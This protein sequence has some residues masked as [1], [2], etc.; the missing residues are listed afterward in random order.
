MIDAVGLIHCLRTPRSCRSFAA[1]PRIVS[2][3]MK[4]QVTTVEQI[5]AEQP[6]RRVPDALLGRLLRGAAGHP[7]CPIGRH[8]APRSARAFNSVVTISLGVRVRCSDRSST[9]YFAPCIRLLD[10]ALGLRS[11]ACRSSPRCRIVAMRAASVRTAR[12][13]PKSFGLDDHGAHVCRH[14]RA[15]HQAAHF[16]LSNGG[17][18]G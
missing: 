1:E 2:V 12:R 18:S 3:G 15:T 17:Y 13:T 7:R 10:P 11:R 14:D 5:G 16:G 9:T 8:Q 4:R 6:V